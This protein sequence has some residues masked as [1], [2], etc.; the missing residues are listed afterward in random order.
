MNHSL[1]MHQDVYDHNLSSTQ[2]ARE[3]HGA[4]MGVLE[5][6]EEAEEATEGKKGWATTDL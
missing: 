2:G 1:K 5:P 4:L 6:G 3:V